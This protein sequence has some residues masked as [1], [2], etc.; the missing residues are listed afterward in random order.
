MAAALSFMFYFLSLHPS[1]LARLRQ[2]V[3]DRVGGTRRPTYE[4]VKEMKYLKAVLNGS[5]FFGR[6]AQ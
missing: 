4:D 3:L 5:F 2:E 1:V 6:Y